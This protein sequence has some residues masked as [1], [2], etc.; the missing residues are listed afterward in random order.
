MNKPE[1]LVGVGDN[2]CA[3][4]AVKNGADAVYFGVRGFNMRDLGT[5]FSVEELPELLSYI[6]GANPL[7]RKLKE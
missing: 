2:T 3:I 5:N 1:L 4:A 7:K 6:H